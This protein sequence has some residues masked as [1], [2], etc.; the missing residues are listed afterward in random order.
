[1]TSS[2]SLIAESHC[3]GRAQY[4]LIRGRLRVRAH[5]SRSAND[6]IFNLKR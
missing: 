5:Y 2:G 6:D 3:G 1:M 4:H